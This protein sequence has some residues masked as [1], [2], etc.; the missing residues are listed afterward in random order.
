MSIIHIYLSTN[1]VKRLSQCDRDYLRRR[2]EVNC[3]LNNLLH[4]PINRPLL[5][6][7]RCILDSIPVPRLKTERQCRNSKVRVFKPSG[8]LI[9]IEYANGRVMKVIGKDNG[10]DST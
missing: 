6:E 1:Q 10:Y 7:L 8:K 4:K 3:L 5:A 2:L 9:R